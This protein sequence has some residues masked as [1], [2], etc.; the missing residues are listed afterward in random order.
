MQEV[1]TNP[2]RVLAWT[3]GLSLSAGAMAAILS[4][5]IGL[6]GMV[7]GIG[8][9]LPVA[10]GTVCAVLDDLAARVWV[11][12]LAEMDQA[13]SALDLERMRLQVALYDHGTVYPDQNGRFPLL[14]DTRG[15]WL[16][17]NTLRQYTIDAILATR[18]WLEDIDARVR[19]LVAARSWPSPG[20]AGAMIPEQAGLTWG[21]YRLTDL[22]QGRQA[23]IHDLVIGARPGPDGTQVVRRSL[24]DLMHV[25]AVGASGWGKST[26]LR[27]LLAQLAWAM[28]AVEVVAI[29]TSGSAL[30]ALRGWR[31]LR[32]P[33]ARS[34]GETIAVLGAVAAEIENRRRMYE[35]YPHV[36]GLA[37]YNEATGANMPPWVIVFDEG[38]H[39]LHQQGVGGPLRD[40]VQTARQYGIYLLLA[41]Q[42][43]KATVI[44]PEIR[45]Q[46]SS[47]FCF[48]TSPPSSRVVIDDSRAADIRDKGR[49]VAQLVGTDLLELQGPWIAKDEFMAA[50]AG[51]GPRYPMPAPAE[52]VPDDLT[53]QVRDMRNRGMTRRQ[54]EL[55]LWGYAGG[56][57]HATVKRILDTTTTADDATGDLDE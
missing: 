50:L 26:W 34:S 47:R 53:E 4:R 33:L 49:A 41:G 56:N 13:R 21:S 42:S 54:I 44:D 55:E 24:H 27:A 57:A 15:R 48:H 31:K 9:T 36:E 6:G 23:S 10:Y 2:G 30:N 25:L 5:N 37:E 28:E 32:Y 17:P 38:T 18:P 14:R 7:T 29:D 46:F 45:D 8:M 52:V 43:A 51:G 11:R 40:V 35:Q 22:L 12:R 1:R 39:A 16:D 3:W 20:T 19:A